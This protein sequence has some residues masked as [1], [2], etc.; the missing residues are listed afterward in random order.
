MATAFA[1]QLQAVALNTSHEFDLRARRNAHA[2]SLIFPKEVAVKQ[3]WDT[4]YQ[5]CVEGCYELC[6]LDNRLNQFERNLFSEQ[7]KDQDRDQLN[8]TQN[9]AL[10]SVIEQCLELLGPR[11]VLRPGV[12]CLEWLVRRFRIHVHNIGALLCTVLPY[13]EQQIFVNV[14]SIVPKDRLVDAWKWL[15]PYRDINA[16]VPRHAVVYAMTNNDGFFDAMNAYVLQATQ[17]GAGD[18]SLMRVWASLVVEAVSGR[19]GQAKSGRKE[20]QRQRTGDVLL[21]VLP[22]VNDGVVLKDCPEMI[23]VCFT[24]SLVMTGTGLLEDVVLDKLMEAVS[25]TLR[26]PTI[27]NKQA[28]VTLS[29][30]AAQK[31]EETAPSRVIKDLLRTSDLLAQL[32]ELRP[33]YPVQKLLHSLIR[34]SLETLK[35]RNYEEKLDLVQK[36]VEAGPALV[37]QADLVSWFVTII[38][39]LQLQDVTDA[40]GDKVRTRLINMLQQLHDSGDLS[41][42]LS[43]VA[44]AYK[45][46]AID[47]EALL[48]SS[49]NTAETAELVDPDAM[50]VDE[51]SQEVCAGGKRRISEEAAAVESFL[52]RDFPLVFS[53][54]TNILQSC[55]SASRISDFQ[56][57]KKRYLGSFESSYPSLLVR[58]VSGDHSKNRRAAATQLLSLYIQSKHQK[59][60]CQVLL[61]YA[62]ALLADPTADVRRAAVGLIKCMAE[63]SKKDGDGGI[64]EIYAKTQAPVPSIIDANDVTRIIEQM[65]LPV[66]EECE[67]D[68]SQIGYVLRHTLNGSPAESAA[69][70]KHTGVELKKN[71]RLALFQNLIDAAIAT[72]LLSFKV[73]ILA[74]LDGVHKVGSTTKLEAFSRLLKYWMKQTQPDASIAAKTETLHL[75]DI[76]RSMASL[77]SAQDRHSVNSVFNLA[78]DL[79][80]EIRTDLVT[81]VFERVAAVYKDMS[82]ETRATAAKLLFELPFCSKPI[83]ARAARST[84]QQFSLSTP[85][86]KSFISESVAT[87]PSESDGPTP[88]RRRTSHGR[89]PPSQLAEAL[90]S[91]IPRLSLTLELVEGSKS[92]SRPE[93]LPNLFDIMLVFRR[94]KGQSQP[95]S[96]Y[97]LNICLG[98]IN[99]ILEKQRGLRR[100]NLDL[101]VIRAD[102]ITDFVRTTES[103]QVQATA[104]QLLASLAALAPERIIHNIMPVFTFMGGDV[105]SKDDE[106]SVNVVNQAI[107][108]IIP[109]LVATL[110][111]QDEGSLIRSTSGILSSFVLA[112]DHIPGHR[113]VRLYQRLLTR[114]GRED[115]GF[116][117]ISMLVVQRSDDDSL[118]SFFGDVLRDFGAIERLVTYRNLVSL[119]KDVFSSKPMLA[120]HLAQT[121]ASSSQLDKQAAALALLETAADLLDSKHLKI[122]AKRIEKANSDETEAIHEEFRVCLHQAL[123]SL[124][125]NKVHGDEIASAIRQCLSNLL[126]LLPPAQ[127]IEALPELLREMSGEDKD[128]K[129]VALRVLAS[130]LQVKAPKDS[131][132]AEAAIAFLQH[133]RIVIGSSDDPLL[134]QAAI[135]CIDRIAEAYGRKYIEEIVEITAFLAGPGINVGSSPEL[136]VG[137][138]LCLASMMEVIK[139]AAVPVVS[140][141]LDR[142]FSVLD[143]LAGGK[144]A[145]EL[146]SATCSVVSTVLA[147]VPYVVDEHSILRM[148]SSLVEKENFVKGKT[149]SEMKKD[150]LDLLAR[151][152]DIATLI[153]C[154]STIWQKTIKPGA[155]DAVTLLDV[156]ASAIRYHSKAEI[157]KSADAIS[158]F[159]LEVFYTIALQADDSEAED[160]SD[161]DAEEPDAEDERTISYVINNIS[162][163]FIYKLNDTSFRPIFESW[164]EW[165]D[166]SERQIAIFRFLRRFFNTLKSIVTSYA[167]Y[168]ITPANAILTSFTTKRPADVSDTDKNL[169]RTLLSTLKSAFTHDADAFFVNPSHF[170][171]LCTN[172]LAQLPLAAHKAFRPLIISHVI[173]S[174]V[175][176]ATA[177]QDT[178]SHHLAINHALC[179]LRHS[180]SSHVRLASIET[181]IALTEDEEVGDEWIN[182]VVSGTNNGEVGRDGGGSGETMIYVNEMLEDDDEEVERKVRMW[183]RMVRER[184]GEDVFEF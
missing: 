95:V 19:F 24:L 50:D 104:L 61:P 92:E 52:V 156:F 5:I 128:L 117:M 109:P 105:L 83:F 164:V 103:P 76:D 172:L 80:F 82:D 28:L 47:L 130:Q 100:P 88:K 158:A 17:N 42:P 138:L 176:I 141:L 134:T 98:C 170:S 79:D 34:G 116:A 32:K 62:T 111:R 39:H 136:D 59:F 44:I 70:I 26:F 22:L 150:T 85:I 147:H 8:K 35:K 77:I 10:D 122:Q 91:A 46:Q 144:G 168:M 1:R 3:D 45:D 146:Y 178:P 110:R 60:N 13:H 12:R 142:S 157:I 74:L 148:L 75:A 149:T 159:V 166:T 15:R 127:Q 143:S 6:Q 154:I 179:Q 167:A 155:A 180:D 129:P 181:H 69:T 120:E 175:A 139:E 16:Q 49:I 23:M 36:I 106:H 169:Y 165:A 119:V 113:K 174:I 68:G 96:P 99:A 67:L 40:L 162:I 21:K 90:S 93:L 123:E 57:S 48:Q 173:P 33:Q 54:L 171:P 152:V 94:L 4:L 145:A 89:A 20:V 140:T 114:L 153:P 107:D 29:I 112:F 131:R 161:D 137:L 160:E 177:V 66:L 121:S 135:Q 72:P 53:A 87:T 64:L 31:E 65:Y 30:L 81:A 118:A 132:T 56:L 183:V 63:A 14:L 124:R 97:L 151:K 25:N 84:L 2:E 115:F 101:S 11:L 163:Q 184:V 78:R 37:E 51:P 43:E 55:I 41:S 73:S 102:V 108:H 7:S 9:E 18:K 86:L 182:N 58:V 38:R 71:Q 126:Q 133:L 27:N 125:D